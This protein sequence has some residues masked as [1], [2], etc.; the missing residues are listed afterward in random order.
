MRYGPIEM[1]WQ[2]LPT[3]R[4]FSARGLQ[5]Q[6]PYAG[7]IENKFAACHQITMALYY[8]SY[9]CRHQGGFVLL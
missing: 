9:I 6:R 7:H 5:E 4:F 1:P 3:L 8:C 2:P